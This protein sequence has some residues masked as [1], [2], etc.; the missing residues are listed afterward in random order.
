MTERMAKLD[1]VLRLVHLLSES[2]E[3]LT[4]DEMAEALNVNRHCRAVA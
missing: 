1:R 3:G 4:L 2:S